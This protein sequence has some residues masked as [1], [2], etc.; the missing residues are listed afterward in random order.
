MSVNFSA[1]Q[2]EQAFDPKI[3]QNWEEPKGKG[4]YPSARE[5]ASVIHANNRGH[6]LPNVPRRR[7]S[8]W[9]TF[10]GT[11]DMPTQIPG[12]RQLNPTARCE[13]VQVKLQVKKEDA[14]EVLSGGLKKCKVPSPLPVKMDQAAQP[15]TTT[16]PP[17]PGSPFQATATRTLAAPNF[18]MMHDLSWPKQGGGDPD[19]PVGNAASPK[20]PTPMPLGGEHVQAQARQVVSPVN[21]E[22]VAVRGAVATPVEPVTGQMRTPEV[23]V[24]WPMARSAEPEVL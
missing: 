15:D 8:P 1:N 5:G 18:P 20:P 12:N 16:H 21:P 24:N 14:A 6:L 7:E 10:V 13:D 11:W 4:K 9:G 19:Q 17:L 3:L 2:Y 23:N 22:Q